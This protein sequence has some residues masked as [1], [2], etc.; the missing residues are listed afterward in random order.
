MENKKNYIVYRKKKFLFQRIG[1]YQTLKILKEN[2]S[3]MPLS[4]FFEELNKESYYNAFYR[5]KSG[6]IDLALI[7]IQDG[8]IATTIRGGRVRRLIKELIAMEKVI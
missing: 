4:A 6:M 8:I 1:L 3:S 7:K 5:V 2:K